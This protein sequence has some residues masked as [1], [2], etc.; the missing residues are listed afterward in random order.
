VPLTGGS[1]VAPTVRQLTHTSHLVLGM[2]GMFGPMTSY[3]LKQRVAATVGNFWFFPHSQLYAEPKRL[4][5][6]GLLR[7]D[8]QP[9]GR[10]RRTY[11]LTPEGQQALRTWLGEPEH[12]RTE[13]RDPGLLKLFFAGQATPDDRRRLAEDQA[14]AHDARARELAE[15]REELAGVADPHAL[16][17]LD[18]GLRYETTVAEFWHELARGS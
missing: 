7:E 12:S 9:G 11:H 17:T 13:V 3:Q 14:G 8:V 15:R 1:S 16:A 4:A 10:R 5:Q 2:L 18:L 6:L